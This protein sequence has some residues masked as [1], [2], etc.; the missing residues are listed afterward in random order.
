MHRLR[1]TVGFAMA[2]VLGLSATASA[3]LIAPGKLSKPHAELDGVSQCFKC[4]ETGQ[5]EIVNGKCLDCHTRIDKR[6]K[7]A[8]G[9]HGRLPP[10]RL[11]CGECHR[12][13]LGRNAD[14]IKWPP[15]GEKKFKHDRTGYPLRH[16]HKKVECRE[17]HDNRLIVD[18]D[19]KSRLREYPAKETYLGLG[20]RCVSC[21]F[22]EHRDQEGDRCESCHTE[23]PW[24][25]APKFNHN[26]D[27]KYP[28]TGLHRKVK[29][30]E[31]H[32][33]LVDNTTP[34]DA[35]PAP[36]SWE[37]LKFVDIPHNSCTNC[38]EDVHNGEFGNDCESC[39][40]TRGWQIMKLS[41]TEGAKASDFHD[42]F[43]YPLDGLHEEVPC[44]QC[45]GPWRGQPV[46][47]T[48]IPF[49]KCTDCHYDA[50]IGQLSIAS[51]PKNRDCSDCHTVQG[52]QPPG[53]ELE[54]HNRESRY[55]LEGAHTSVPCNECHLK[56]VLF[57]KQIPKKLKREIARQTRD[58]QF[59]LTQFVWKGLGDQCEDCHKD[60][61]RGQFADADP[62]KNCVGCHIQDSWYTLRFD[63]NQDSRFAL[64]GA[65]ERVACDSC[66]YP[67]K[68]G[69]PVVYKPL[70]T[71]CS[72]CHFDIHLG[73]FA[74]Q[75][76]GEQASFADTSCEQCHTT[77]DFTSS[78]TFD[79]NDP[80]YSDY[81]LEG[82]HIDVACQDCHGSVSVNMDDR[83]LEVV[84]YRPVP[85]TCIGCHDD[86]HEG[87]LAGV[88]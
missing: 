55:A 62:A 85:K 49:E 77:V 64:E 52:Y 1:F 86:Y 88:E 72:S 39:H 7:K 18:R 29:C 59:C 56:N 27:S 65:H 23:Q 46:K 82:R 28:L 30:G 24:K 53:F 70:S 47:Y 31:C 32:P 69:G 5:K 34:R 2:T 67:E 9:Y 60:I 21:H 68:S 66:H 40:T 81:P 35:F 84:R 41:S 44:R 73:Q 4:H 22:D 3:Q 16:E 50:H 54:D 8:K 10:Q 51:K 11:A 74:E 36:E 63:H 17:C 19:V 20:T 37:Y 71:E 13:H 57:A 43:A 76:P 25:Q 48:G 87:T 15:E 61:H 80:S 38:H 14:I 33:T 12:E 83:T 26:R 78:N 75:V 6:I 42:D 58:E 45:H 79:H